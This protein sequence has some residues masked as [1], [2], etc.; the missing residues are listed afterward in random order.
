MDSQWSSEAVAVIARENSC[1]MGRRPGYEASGHS[2]YYTDVS[3]MEWLEFNP[4]AFVP[5]IEI[6]L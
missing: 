5:T 3:P 4:M 2:L 6:S 1:N